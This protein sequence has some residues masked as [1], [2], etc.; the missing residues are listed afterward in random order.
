MKSLLK[1]CTV[2][3]SVLSMTTAAVAQEPLQALGAG[4][5]ALSIVAWAGYIER[6]ETDKNFD[7]VTEF[8]KKTGCMVSVKT[9]ATSD[10]MVA[11]MNEGGFDLVTASGDASLRLV[12]GKRVQP[13]NTALIPS[14]STIDERLQNAPWHTKDGVHYG[15]PYVWGPNVLMYNTQAFG[16]K[17][18]DSW[19]VVF[20]EMTLADGKSNKGRVQAY[21]GPIHVADAA[22]YL[23]FHK[24]ELG[25]KDPFE[26]NEDQY[27]AALDLLRVQRTLVSRYW[28]DAF[29]QIDDFKNEGVVASG[30]WPFQVNLLKADQPVASV[31]P[32]EGVTG[33]ADTTMLHVDSEHPNCAYMWMEHSLSPKVQGDVSAWFGT[34]PSVP[35]ACKGNALLGDEGCKNNGYENFEKIKFWKTPVSKCESQGECVPYHRWVS[36]YI[37]VI[38]GR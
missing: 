25:I 36:D 19:N 7:W 27:K 22:N 4:E 3:A 2:L 32:K 8:E 38:G 14:W 15:T 29:I 33:W 1:S 26:L 9:A 31:F 30:S 34:V 16:D 13:I 20:E 21:D 11:L 24:P 28:H 17:A 35:A 37:G 18:P 23:M 5:G 10:E 6:G 12:A